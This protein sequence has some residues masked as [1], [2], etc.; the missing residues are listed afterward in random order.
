MNPAILSKWKKRG[1]RLVGK[2]LLFLLLFG[3]CFLILYP[4]ALKILSAC[5]DPVDLYDKT[6]GLIPKHVSS[7]YFE[8]A[9][10]NLDVLHS[11]MNTLVLSLLASGAQVIT[12]TMVA[13]GL[14]R[15]R[16]RGRGLLF[17]L[18]ILVLLVPPQFYNVALYLRIRSLG[19]LNNP[20]S[21][22]LL[23]IT[24]IGF[25]SGLYIYLLRNFFVNLPKELESAA[26]V[27][28][29]GPF[30]AFLRVI[31]P[32]ASLMMSTVFL[33][34]F[35]WQWTDTFYTDLLFSKYSTLGKVISGIQIYNAAGKWFDGYATTIVQNAA[36]ILMLLPLLLVFLLCQ[37]FLIKSIATSGLAN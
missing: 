25:K 17:L 21:I 1:I 9:L 23:S 11:G 8:L 30:T 12:C 19:L 26:Y 18:V 10:Q 15:F 2:S 20:L 4:F 37:K 6:V 34:S 31:L 32:N 7:Y 16:F 5:K 35:C 24:G 29:A 28:G 36:C 13:Y 33:F 27:D 14:A 22:F 3:F